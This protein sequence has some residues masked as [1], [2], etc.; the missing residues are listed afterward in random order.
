MSS[1]I[2]PEI[3]AQRREA[4]ARI[5]Q[6]TRVQTVEE[7]VPDLFAAP[8]VEL[9]Y[10][11]VVANSRL[12]EDNLYLILVVGNADTALEDLNRAHPRASQ[13]RLYHMWKVDARQQIDIRKPLHRYRDTNDWYKIPLVEALR[14]VDP[15]V[16]LCSGSAV[17]VAPEPA[18]APETAAFLAAI[19]SYFGFTDYAL[20]EL[21]VA[22]AEITAKMFVP[23]LT[24]AAREH[25]GRWDEVTYRRTLGMLRHAELST[26]V[27]VIWGAYVPPPVAFTI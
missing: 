19:E 5:K 24:R 3:V 1:D 25:I 18:D 7:A 11:C 2:T 10:V 16:K 21:T 23:H 14:V 17:S 27:R 15:I 12:A 8:A 9:Q 26:P 4:L 20:H 22:N 6:F 13:L